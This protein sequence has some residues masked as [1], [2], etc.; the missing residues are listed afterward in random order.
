MKYYR[1]KPIAEVDYTKS[2]FQP[3]WTCKNLFCNCEWV[4]Y[5]IPV[6]GWIA[7]KIYIPSNGEYANS[8]KIKYCPNYERKKKIVQNT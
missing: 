7:E 1:Q 5:R 4:K 2:D 3:C 8:Y 6:N